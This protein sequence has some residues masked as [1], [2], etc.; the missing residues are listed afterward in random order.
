MPCSSEKWGGIECVSFVFLLPKRDFL[1]T[2]ARRVIS[3][4]RNTYAV[5]FLNFTCSCLFCLFSSTLSMYLSKGAY[6]TIY[7]NINNIFNPIF[8]FTYLSTHKRMTLSFHPNNHHML[9][10]RQT[11]FT[12]FIIVELLDW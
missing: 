6:Q 9:K 5:F 8:V 1:V 2:H 12:F 11:L 7:P 4:S 10:S 3:K